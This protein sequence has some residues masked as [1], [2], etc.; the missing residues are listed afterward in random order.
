[1]IGADSLE[2]MEIDDLHDMVGDLPVCKACFNG[3]Y[4]D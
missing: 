4:P 2:Y 3:E 1:M